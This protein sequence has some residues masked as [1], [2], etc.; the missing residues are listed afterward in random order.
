MLAGASE[1][2]RGSHRA[3]RARSSPS[4]SCSIVKFAS[5]D[6]DRSPSAGR[7]PGARESLS[8]RSSANRA[9]AGRSVADGRAVETRATRARRGRKRGPLFAPPAGR[10]WPQ[11]PDRA[12]DCHS[13]KAATSV[14]DDNLDGG[15]AE[16]VRILRRGLRTAPAAAL[17]AAGV[18]EEVGADSDAG[19]SFRS[20]PATS[21][22]S[23]RCPFAHFPTRRIGVV[24]FPRPVQQAC[25]P[26][27]RRP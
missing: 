17:A 14:A 22:G 21:G 19:R 16:V 25:R 13:L 4:R 18:E 3:P 6:R 24:A 8:L 12:K 9:S 1:H 20:P 23:A 7:S 5:A 2:G 10:T 11:S 15:P 27:R 26:P